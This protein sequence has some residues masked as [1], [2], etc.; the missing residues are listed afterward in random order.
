M[1]DGARARRSFLDTAAARVLALAVV[2]A[3]VR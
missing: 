3:R 1:T 2:L